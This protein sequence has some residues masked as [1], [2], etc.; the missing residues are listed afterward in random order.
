MK[1]HL[2]DRQLT[3]ENTVIVPT[4]IRD[5]K[6]YDGNP[7][8]LVGTPGEL[9]PDKKKCLCS[10]CFNSLADN[11]EAK[12]RLNMDICNRCNGVGK[13]ERRAAGEFVR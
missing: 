7:Y 10:N 9:L 12:A 11:E 3:P 1:C 13:A 5:C 8:D 6:C 4:F 2:C